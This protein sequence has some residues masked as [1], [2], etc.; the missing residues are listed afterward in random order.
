MVSVQ[1]FS[2]VVIAITIAHHS[3]LKVPRSF[4]LVHVIDMLCKGCNNHLFFLYSVFFASL[5]LFYK[6]LVQY[7]YNYNN[8][9]IYNLEFYLFFWLTGPI[10]FN[11][12]IYLLV[13]G[14]VLSELQ[15]IDLYWLPGGYAKNQSLTLFLF[16]FSRFSLI[17]FWDF[18]FCY[19]KAVFKNT[20][21]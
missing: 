17:R 2:M 14:I 11:F 13:V 16:F 8:K 7:T 1:S 6:P 18:F 10:L 4:N 3:E 19:Q 15:L 12:N 5:I 21:V 9:K 20:F